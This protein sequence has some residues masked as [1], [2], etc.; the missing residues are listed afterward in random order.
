[1]PSP[2]RGRLESLISE[3]VAPLIIT[4][5]REQGLGIISLAHVSVSGKND[6]VELSLESLDGKKDF[7]KAFQTLIPQVRS[8]LAKSRTFGRRAPD[9]RFVHYDDAEK[10]QRELVALIERL[11]NEGK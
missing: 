7:L 10:S 6:F 9:V 3:L 2:L 5:A 4:H 8:T 11:A 1:M